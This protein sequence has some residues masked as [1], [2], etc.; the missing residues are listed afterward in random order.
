MQAIKIMKKI[1]TLIMLLVSLAT[2]N[3]KC[4]W[5]SVNIEEMRS[6]NYFLWRITGDAFKDTCVKYD[7]ELV[8]LSTN[9]LL[10][11]LQKTGLFPR[12]YLPHKGKYLFGLKLTNT[13]T[14]CDTT[15][16]DS[17]DYHYYTHCVF[18]Y[19]MLSTYDSTCIDS[20]A[21]E[22]TKGTLEPPSFCWRYSSRL[23]CGGNLNKFTDD[24]WA[25]DSTIFNNGISYAGNDVVYETNDTLDAGRK[26]N[27]KFKKPGRYLLMLTWSHYCAGDDTVIL[28]RFTI[29]PC[30]TLGTFEMVKPEPKLIGMYDMLGRPVKHIRKDEVIILLYDDGSKK[31]IISQ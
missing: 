16:Y 9:K 30:V 14:G 17:V 28:I 8:D 4:T 29:D 7:F 3:A 11:N 13:C 12:V 10:T 31:K 15:I 5:G 2:A 20:F 18:N 6:K 19:K 1:L 21:G 26:L 22:M 25:H 24:Q 23:L 27:Y